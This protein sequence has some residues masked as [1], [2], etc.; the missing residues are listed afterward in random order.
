M[1]AQRSCRPCSAIARPVEGVFGRYHAPS[2]SRQFAEQVVLR[3]TDVQL[4]ARLGHP[5]LLAVNGQI[6]RS[7]V[8]GLPGPPQSRPDPR[9]QI[10]RRERPDHVVGRPY[11]S[12]TLAIVPSQPYTDRKMTGRSTGAG[13]LCISLMPSVPG[14]IRSSTTKSGASVSSRRATST[15]APVVSAS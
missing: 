5:A 12:K 3:H 8:P 13:R 6:P 15:G 4:P 2:S 9:H 10:R 11:L 7:V 1:R 14:S